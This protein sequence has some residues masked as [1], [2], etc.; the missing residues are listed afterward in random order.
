MQVHW[1]LFLRMKKFSKKTLAIIFFVLTCLVM[2]LVCIFV[3][4]PLA[5]FVSTPEEF[6]LWIESFGVW[7]SL[8]FILL[9]AF[10]TV[11]AFIPGEPFELFAGYAFG[12][13]KGTVFS[14]L[15]IA[16]GSIIVFAF[17]KKFGRK[18]VEIFFSKEKID[19]VKFLNDKK[20]LYTITFI[21]F[22]IPGTP[23]DLLTY[24]SGLTPVKLWQW[25][26]LTTIARIPS[27]VTST[28]GG[29]ALGEKKYI[30]AI[31]VFGITLLISVIGLLIYNKINSTKGVE[32]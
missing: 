29:N 32:K 20:R 19:S 1:Q 8:V 30:F 4:I 22:F 10:Q 17:T 26:L 13:F 23:K 11:F 3:G 16:L 18:F 9:T 27:I 5:R 21:L 25:L 2:A 24:V 12:F 7:G 14:M 28:V 31:I 15:G 6:R